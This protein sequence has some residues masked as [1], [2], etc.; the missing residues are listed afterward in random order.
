MKFWYGTSVEILERVDEGRSLYPL[1]LHVHPLTRRG[2]VSIDREDLPSGV[3]I[4]RYSL[5]TKGV[6]FL[7]FLR[8][9]DAKASRPLFHDLEEEL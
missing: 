5:T 2:Y 8:E 4:L 6:K 7:T 1:S 3:Y 9:W